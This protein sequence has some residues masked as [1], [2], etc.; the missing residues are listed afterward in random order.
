MNNSTS[1]SNGLAH[2]IAATLANGGG[3]TRFEKLT[4]TNQ[5]HHPTATQQQNS[6]QQHPVGNGLKEFLLEQQ[7]QQH[8]VRQTKYSLRLSVCSWKT[9][10]GVTPIDSDWS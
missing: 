7:Q 9:P 2:G 10:I 1:L 6:H 5:Q 4:L 8:V 3:E